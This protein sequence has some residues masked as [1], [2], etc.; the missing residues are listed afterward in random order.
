MKLLQKG[1]RSDQ[2]SGGQLCGRWR[3]RGRSRQ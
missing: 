2:G 3:C 1:L